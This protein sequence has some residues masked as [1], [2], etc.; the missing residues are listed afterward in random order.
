MFV[1]IFYD[2][3]LG[4]TKIILSYFAEFFCQSL[5]FALINT[6][7]LQFESIGDLSRNFVK[8]IPQKN[9]QKNF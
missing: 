6:C 8:N 9:T 5:K 4:V 2:S 1:M 3:Y 7:I